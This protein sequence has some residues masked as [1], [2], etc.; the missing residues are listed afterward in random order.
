M[1]QHVRLEEIGSNICQTKPSSSGEYDF[2]YYFT[3]KVIYNFIEIEEFQS[4]ILGNLDFPNSCH[5][6]KTVGHTQ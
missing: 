5:R 6:Y 2:L 1:Q 3:L 4:T